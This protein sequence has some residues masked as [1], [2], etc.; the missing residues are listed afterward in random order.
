[1]RGQKRKEA[2]WYSQIETFTNSSNIKSYSAVDCCKIIINIFVI[3]LVSFEKATFTPDCHIK[4]AGLLGKNYEKKF[5]DEVTRSSVWAYF[6]PLRGTSF[7]TRLLSAPLEVNIQCK[8]RGNR[9][10]VVCSFYGNENF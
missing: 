2:Q 7:K 10:I 6:A 5:R 1:M 8:K 4:K 3:R 9:A